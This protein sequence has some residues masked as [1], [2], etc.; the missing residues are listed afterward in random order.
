MKEFDMVE[1]ETE[2]FRAHMPELKE[3]TH[4]PEKGCPDSASL[5]DVIRTY[6][7]HE[8]SMDA[9]CG[10]VGALGVDRQDRGVDRDVDLGDIDPLVSCNL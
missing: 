9:R 2:A 10:S 8:D 6:A 5:L 7:A 1:G 3:W 4:Y